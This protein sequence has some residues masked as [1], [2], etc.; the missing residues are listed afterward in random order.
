MVTNLDLINVDL[1]VLFPHLL[2]RDLHGVDGGHGVPEVVGGERGALHVK[3]L[4][5]QLRDLGFVHAFL[6]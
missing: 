1:A 5:C 6:L 2:V 3:R 4:L